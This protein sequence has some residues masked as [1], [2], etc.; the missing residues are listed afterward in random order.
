MDDAVL[1]KQAQSILEACRRAQG[2]LHGPGPAKKRVS[3]A[4]ACFSA[5]TK[6]GPLSP[7]VRDVYYSRTLGSIEPSLSVLE[8]LAE[9]F[10]K[11]DGELRGE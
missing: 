3:A 4:A 7:H 1:R 6:D 2:Y 11:A 8:R 5:Y 10:A 9:S